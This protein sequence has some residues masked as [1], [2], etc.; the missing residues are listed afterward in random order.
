[1]GTKDNSLVAQT[2]DGGNNAALAPGVREEL[3]SYTRDTSAGNSAVDEIS[4]PR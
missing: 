2:G 4:K 3:G 1:M